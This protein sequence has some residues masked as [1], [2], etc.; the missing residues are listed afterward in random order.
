MTAGDEVPQYE[1]D[2]NDDTFDYQFADYDEQADDYAA[3][4]GSSSPMNS[5]NMRPA[6]T[7]AMNTR[8]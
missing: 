1:N 7:L 6:M 8:P 5:L 2:P 4:A 3:A